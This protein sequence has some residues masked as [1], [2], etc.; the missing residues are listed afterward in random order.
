MS[1]P[2]TLEKPCCWLENAPLRENN[3]NNKEYCKSVAP[4]PG[5]CTRDIG[6]GSGRTGTFFARTRPG[7]GKTPRL[8]DG[9]NPGDTPLPSCDIPA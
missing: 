5:S 3:E 8:K 9:E 7:A 1:C 6:G 2:R 4:D